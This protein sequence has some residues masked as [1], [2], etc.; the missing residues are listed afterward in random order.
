MIERVWIIDYLT[1]GVILYL[2]FWRVWF[3]F[4]FFF[5][6]FSNFS[7]FPDQSHIILVSKHKLPEWMDE[8]QHELL[9]QIVHKFNPIKL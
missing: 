2:L 8:Q 3:P 1:G 5:W 9:K 6:I 4:L 7:T